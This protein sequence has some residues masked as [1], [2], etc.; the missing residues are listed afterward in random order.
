MILENDK[1]IICGNKKCQS[2]NCV[3]RYDY[4]DE[5]DE[6]ESFLREFYVCLDCGETEV[7]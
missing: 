5:E 2:T 1:I 3:V 7:I 6:E 4:Y